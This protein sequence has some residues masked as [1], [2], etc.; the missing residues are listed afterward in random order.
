MCSAL[1]AT[2]SSKRRYPGYSLSGIHAYHVGMIKRF[3]LL[4]Q[5][6]VL[7]FVDA[8]AEMIGVFDRPLCMDDSSFI[9]PLKHFLASCSSEARLSLVGPTATRWDVVRFLSNLLRF[10]EEEKANRQILDQPIERPIFITGLPRS[11]TTFLH[12]LMMIDSMNRCPLV[13]ET[14]FPYPQRG[15]RDHRVSHVARQLKAFELLAPEFGALHTTLLTG[16]K[17]GFY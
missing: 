11:G 7:R 5:S 2:A 16:L 14:I 9:E 10:H 1:P 15:Q 4:L 3:C 13:W 17:S 6:T 8:L 12:R